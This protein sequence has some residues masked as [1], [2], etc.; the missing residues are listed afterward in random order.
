MNLGLALIQCELLPALLCHL[1]LPAPDSNVRD[2]ATI[3]RACLLTCL[4]TTSSPMSIAQSVSPFLTHWATMYSAELLS[5]E[6]IGAFCLPNALKHACDTRGCA[7]PREQAMLN[8]TFA[9]VIPASSKAFVPAST[10]P[11]VRS[12]DED[13]DIPMPAIWTR[14]AGIALDVRWIVV[15]SPIFGQQ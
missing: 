6:S 7:S 12:S 3:L 11:L 1:D 13:D 14:V 10:A 4:L 5:A 15:S 9:Y 8:C 2:S